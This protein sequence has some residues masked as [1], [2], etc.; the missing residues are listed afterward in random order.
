VSTPGDI[1]LA[2]DRDWRGYYEERTG[3]PAAEAE[4]AYVRETDRGA[5][6]TAI[7]KHLD[8]SDP[9]GGICGEFLGLWKMT[10]AGARRFRHRFEEID[11]RLGPGEPFRESAGWQ[12]A[13]VTDLFGDLIAS[14][15]E[16]RCLLIERGWAELD[17]VQDFERLPSMIRAQRLFSLGASS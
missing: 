11:A 12:R 14:N 1:V 15:H 16:I 4:K 2:V 5:V 9:N 6:L 10:R 13:Y 8:A 7:G 17:V 3:H